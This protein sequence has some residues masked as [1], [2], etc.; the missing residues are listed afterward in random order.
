MADSVYRLHLELGPRAQEA[1]KQLKKDMEARSHSE[2]IR[3]A[4][5]VIEKLV[6]EVQAGASVLIK[7]K[8][9]DQVEILLPGVGEVTKRH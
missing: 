2:V 4:L 3:T 5:Q 1:L 6:K 8:D 9:G 7:R